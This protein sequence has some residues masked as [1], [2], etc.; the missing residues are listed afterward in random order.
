MKKSN[1]KKGRRDDFED[2]GFR[3]VRTKPKQSDRHSQRR[4]DRAIRTKNI[5]LLYDDE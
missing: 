2:D 3:N 1:Y 4:V 5:D